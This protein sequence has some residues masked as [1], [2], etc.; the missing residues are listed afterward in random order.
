MLQHV[1]KSRQTNFVLIF[2]NKVN[3]FLIHI[4][5]NKTIKN[6]RLY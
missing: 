5:V 1:K 3:Y 6:I 4:M 2:I